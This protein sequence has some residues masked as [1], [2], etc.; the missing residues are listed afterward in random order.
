[1]KPR[2]TTPGN[3]GLGKLIHQRRTACKMTQQELAKPLGISASNVSHIECGRV[4]LSIEL[5]HRIADVLQVPLAYFFQTDEANGLGDSVEEL[6]EPNRYR[7]VRVIRPPNRKRLVDPG[8]RNV[9][10]ELLSPDHQRN[11]EFLLATYQPGAR[12]GL[13]THEGEECGILLEGTLE[14]VIEGEVHFLEKGD[15][16]YFECT[17]PHEARNPS[18]DQIARAIWVVSPPSF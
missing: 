13:M 8:T 18:V 7:P 16:I 4:S 14:V 2:P 15:S 11:M 12:V 10:W 9:Q 5:L 1:M 17:R 3:P 6:R